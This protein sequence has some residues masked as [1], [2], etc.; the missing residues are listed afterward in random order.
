VRAPAE[1]SS[2]MKKL[3]IGLLAL[4]V[5]IV[6][7]A[8]VAPFLIPT[9][10]YKAKLIALV[11]Q[12]TGRA[13]RIDG[14]VQLS[15]LPQ[16]AVDA[17]DV[18][19]ANAPGAAT[20]DMMRLKQLEVRLKVLPLLHGAI[21]LGRF[22]LTDPVIALEVDRA[23]RPNW[24]MTPAGAAPGKPA[25][26]TTPAAP[27]PAATGGG[28]SQISEL[29]LDDVRIIDGKISYRD[30]R[31]GKTETV[32]QVNMALSLPGLD[33]PFK[34]Q[35]SLVWNGQKL[36]LGATIAKPRALLEG[37]ASGFA[38]NLSADPVDFSFSGDATGMPPAK[39]GGTVNLTVPSLRGLAQWVGSPLPPGGG[40]GRL[41]IQGRF[42]MAGPKIGFTNAT[43]ALDAIKAQGAVT[44]RTGGPRPVLDGQLQVDKLDLNPYL[45]PEKASGAK[46]AG[47]G[48]APKSAGGSRAAAAGWS[49][50]PIDL[51]ELGAADADFA[52]KAGGILY[53]KIVV[54]PSALDL[55][56]KGGKLT[57]DL[58]QLTLYQGK[59]KGKVVLDGSGPVPA[60]ALDFDLSGLEMEPLLEA[61]A[62]MDRFSGTGKLSL[63]VT[64]RGKSQR[65]IIGALDGK[66]ALDLA[67][68]AIKGVD[69]ISLAENPSGALS[70][71]GGKTDFGSL[72]G[73]F[74]ITNGVVKNDDLQ[75]KSG[76]VPVTGAGTVNL[77]TRT[78]DYRVTVSLAGAIGVPVLVTGPWDDLSYRPDVGSMLKGAAQEPGKALNQLKQLA[79]GGGS[80]PNP[81]SLLKGLF[82]K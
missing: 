34:G 4:I 79:P 51:S 28:A 13:L 49:D 10:T 48:A 32:D 75:L 26:A 36:T 68:G 30:D 80:T 38:M 11:E 27:A 20:P 23:G 1:E 18:S 24:V 14:P 59:G 35:G 77:P 5:L 56:L 73:T 45:P 33:N 66:G 74:T 71:K 63:D 6:V 16:L 19:F 67:N 7:V 43:I 42:D 53:R 50:A 41:A 54:G 12:S 61:A 22:V 9:A 15:F 2:T 81:S 40:L 52:L 39:L 78:V 69:L 72:T 64:G 21:E 47:G 31:T 58:S 60:L 70:G 57:A 62:G 29:R 82:G 55:H 44:L 8:L 37:K 65:A 76:V 25:S 3:L 17:S 46:P